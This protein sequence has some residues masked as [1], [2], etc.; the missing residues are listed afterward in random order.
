MIQNIATP[1][2]YFYS[3]CETL[4]GFLRDKYNF[5]EIILDT[6]PTNIGGLPPG[7]TMQEGLHLLPEVRIVNFCREVERERK[8]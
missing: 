4:I 3:I 6:K 5:P 2:I 1:R 8:R 7:R